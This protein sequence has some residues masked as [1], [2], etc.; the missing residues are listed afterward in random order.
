MDVNIGDR[1]FFNSKHFPYL[2]RRNDA[3]PIPSFYWLRI[4][5]NRSCV[6]SALLCLKMSCNEHAL[7]RYIHVNS[8]IK[9]QL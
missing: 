1:Y 2:Q 7:L 6:S 8:E 5:S 4:I 9:F 3:N